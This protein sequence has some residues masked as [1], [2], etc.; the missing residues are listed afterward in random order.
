VAVIC[1]MGCLTACTS[2]HRTSLPPTASS[3]ST[4]QQAGTITGRLL[5][6]GGPAGTSSRPLPGSV[7]LEGAG[8]ARI[9]TVDNSGEFSTR[10][11]PGLYVLRGSSPQ[12][13]FVYPI[14]QHAII[15]YPCLGVSPVAVIADQTVPTEVVCSEK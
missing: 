1:L 13:H 8:A 5:A 15:E 14:E 7:V 6:V 10:V 9:I 11:R 4:V 3:T 2:L 12:F